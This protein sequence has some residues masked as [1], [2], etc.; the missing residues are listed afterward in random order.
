MAVYHNLVKPLYIEE[1]GVALPDYNGITHDDTH[2]ASYLITINVKGGSSYKLY[3]RGSK[4]GFYGFS[5]TWGET[6]DINTIITPQQQ[7]AKGIYT[8]T[9]Q[10][11]SAPRRGIN[12]IDGKKVVV[13]D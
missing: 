4:L 12:I 1:D 3:C 10:R 13:R 7:R 11:L 8:I 2:P 5:Y 9:G 6:T